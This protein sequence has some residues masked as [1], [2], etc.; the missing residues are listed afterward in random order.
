MTNQLRKLKSAKGLALGAGC[1]YGGCLATDEVFCGTRGC[2]LP[3]HHNTGCRW[4]ANNRLATTN[5]LHA[6]SPSHS[7]SRSS[8]LMSTTCKDNI[9][10]N[11]QKLQ[12]FSLLLWQHKLGTLYTQTMI[13]ERKLL[14][15]LLVSTERTSSC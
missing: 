15:K 12:Y 11:I 2:P 13:E 4:L 7:Y 14:N 9:S 10:L 5:S 3:G 6:S 1:C 8:F